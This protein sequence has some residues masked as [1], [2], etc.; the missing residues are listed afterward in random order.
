M[1]AVLG[2]IS[3][4]LVLGTM[5]WL[6][7]KQLADARPASVSERVLPTPTAAQEVQQYKQA[8]EGLV[9]QPRVLPDDQ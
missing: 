1:R 6:A 8:I 4:L 9:Q 7:K 3:L 2:I 5:G